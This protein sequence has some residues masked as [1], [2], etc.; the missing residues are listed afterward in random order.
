MY[1]CSVSE[2]DEERS[3]SEAL[4][5]TFLKNVDNLSTILQFFVLANSVNS[6]MASSTVVKEPLPCCIWIDL[7]FTSMPN[8]KANRAR[9][10]R[11]IC[12]WQTLGS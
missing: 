9:C 5:E 4:V 8:M 7:T 6:R 2:G 11:G 1:E 3:F 10:I 12:N